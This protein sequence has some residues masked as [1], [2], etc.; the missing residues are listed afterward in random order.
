MYL[1]QSLHTRDKPDVVTHMFINYQL[2]A[3]FWSL[4][5]EI[6]QLNLSSGGI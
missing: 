2:I 6:T 3:P 5:Q 1:V 4:A